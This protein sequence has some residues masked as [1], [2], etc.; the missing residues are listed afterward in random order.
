MRAALRAIRE[1]KGTV[2]QLA[3]KHP[4]VAADL[5]AIAVAAEGLAQQAMPERLP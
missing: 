2:D 3:A 5:R 1:Q 4:D